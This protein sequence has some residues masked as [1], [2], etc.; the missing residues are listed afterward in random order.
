MRDAFDSEAKEKGLPKLLLTVAV[1][2]GAETVKGGYDVP[3][4]AR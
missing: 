3:N 2:A 1:S 4:V